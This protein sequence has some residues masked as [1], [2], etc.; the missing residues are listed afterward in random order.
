M[1]SESFGLAIIDTGC[2]KTTAGRDWLKAYVDTLS[3]KDR[4]SISSS[5]S[6]N[7]FR[8]GDGKVYKSEKYVVLP[9]YI[10]GKQHVLG[11]EIVACNIPLLLSRETLV[12][13]HACIDIFNNSIE[14]LGET[15]PLVTTN[16]GHI[17]LRIGR[18]FDVDEPETQRVVSSV[19]FSSPLLNVDPDDLKKK[20]LKL[21]KQFAHPPPGK[22]VNLI[23]NAGTDAPNIENII[24]EVSS[25]CEVCKKHQR[26]PSRP[27]VGFPC[28][29]RFNQTVALDLKFVG[30]RIM[31]H[32]IDHLTRYSS[33]CFIP[34]KH[35]ETIVKALF[36]YWIRIFGCPTN[37]LSDNGGEFINQDVID[38][39]EKCNIVLKTTAAESAWS[40]GLCERHNGILGTMISKLVRNNDCSYDLAVHWA[41]AAKNSL[42]NVY[43]FSPN[44]LVFGR[45]PNFPSALTNKPPADN[46]TCLSQ[47]VADNLNMMHQ[48]RQVFI[49]QESAERLRRGLNRKTRSYSNVTFC[50]G[51]LVYYW[52][53]KSTECHGPAVVIGRDGQQVLV[54]HGGQY[55]RVH[56]CR[57]QLANDDA[58]IPENN[59]SGDS[60]VTIDP[61]DFQNIATSS[62]DSE[63]TVVMPQE[64][65]AACSDS[66]NDDGT[67][68]SPGP[69]HLQQE[70]ALGADEWNLVRCPRDLPKLKTNVDCRFPGYDTVVKCKILS[71]AG[72]VSTPSWHFLNVQETEQS[73][74]K[75]C[76]FEGVLWKPSVPDD[77][78]NEE[79][80]PSPAQGMPTEDDTQT[81]VN[82][83]Q[84][85]ENNP[86]VIAYTEV[87]YSTPSLDAT[88][89]SQPKLDEIQKWKDLNT[90]EEVPNS[91]QKCIS[92]RWVCTRKV[93]GGQ[94]VHK[95]RLVARGFEED[96]SA[97]KTDSPTC[98]KESFRIL[99]AIVAANSW[100][101]HSLDVK[102]AFLQGIPINR[103]VYIKPPKEANA[104]GVWKMLKCPYGL[105]DS[106]RHW[107]LKVQQVFLDLGVVQSK[108]DQALFMWYNDGSLSGIMACHVDDFIFGGT[109]TYHE[110]V[111]T[112]IR[113]LFIV[114][115]EENTSMK[116][117]GL[118]INQDSEG[119][120]VSTKS[121]GMSLAQFGSD[122]CSQSSSSTFSSDQLTAIK[123]SSGQI[124]WLV[125]QSRP[126]IAYD[127]CMIANSMNSGN[128]KVFS[129]INKCIRRI[130]NQDVVL[131]FYSCMDIITC[132]VVTFCDASFGNLPNGGSQ[133]SF[134][135][136]LIDQNGT[137]CPIAW[138]S[139]KIRRVVKSTIAAECLAAVEAAEITVFLAVFLKN[140][141]KL[142]EGSVKTLLLCDNNNLVTSAH[143][144]TN[145][146]DKRL[147][148]DIS[149]LR[150]LLNTGELNEFR[151]VNTKLQVANS[152]TKTGACDKDLMQILNS[153]LCFDNDTSSFTSA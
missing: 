39:A 137:Y 22:L 5:A 19:L 97:L 151:W 133:G 72:K 132:R 55:V 71:R 54:K 121:Y 26:R 140:I 40:N 20:V 70:E 78:I 42:D 30:S 47:H 149:V 134:I 6:T 127:S 126:D 35:K 53:D 28:A 34:N 88:P 98:S 77:V 153:K 119:I 118:Q 123:Q 90:F 116:Y 15:M 87:F 29:T 152:L 146:E 84:E 92:T 94:V 16:S 86:P 145:L 74:G 3:I 27:A 148:I 1:V 99:L 85:I 129:S 95:A 67:P 124:N 89:F 48:A 109:K 147:I 79:S 120:H 130:Q 17:S 56:P 52:R 141:L 80:T 112:R 131:H 104:A 2:P 115:L 31:L 23:R 114:G 57:L 7:K 82:E 11:V 25:N 143:S 37:F 144:S 110:T 44:V 24:N 13:A 60:R 91:G 73:E 58:N 65:Q 61:Q 45:N 33:A 64:H 50:Q 93:K 49:Q 136:F 18:S 21:H 83:N 68:D 8:F 139:R 62:P 59:V 63:N 76:S 43:G 66:E 100:K 108:L 107:Y 12:R 69:V 36:E 14:L 46:I 128:A 135:S 96:V 51:D 113:S 9:I 142:P 101:L 150:D 38:L 105:A 138:Q 102:S 10:N 41:V 103:E 4:A 111:I 81:A 125:M 117:L 106:G 75:C 32:M 122:V